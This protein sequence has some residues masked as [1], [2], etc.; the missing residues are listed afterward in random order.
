MIPVHGARIAIGLVCLLAAPRVRAES[1]SN[2]TPD[3][4]SPRPEAR[5]RYTLFVRSE[6]V[7]ELFRRAL[8]PGANGALVE[9]RAALPIHEVL[10]VQAAGVDAP[11]RADSLDFEFSAWG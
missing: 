8:L 5:D 6:T 2:Q 7:V 4:Q 3:A 9:T 10:A 11:W 1:G